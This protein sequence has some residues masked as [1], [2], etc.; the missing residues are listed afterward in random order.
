MSEVTGRAVQAPHRTRTIVLGV[1]V[2]LLIGAGSFW[3]LRTVFHVGRSGRVDL[4]GEHPRGIGGGNYFRPGCFDLSTCN[5]L[6]GF[7]DM[8]EQRQQAT[9]IYVYH[10]TELVVLYTKPPYS[11]VRLTTGEHAGKE[12][13]IQTQNIQLDWERPSPA[14]TRPR[15]TPRPTAAP[16]P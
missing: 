5:S 8:E 13:W 9:L 15:A 4:I 3:L 14:P 12:V 10:N 2:V 7:P 11:R 16:A 1:V 6:K